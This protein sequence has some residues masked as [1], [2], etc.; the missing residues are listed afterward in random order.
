MNA[1]PLEH[2]EQAAFT[3]WLELQGLLFTA[4]AQSTYTKSWSQK[5][6]NNATGLRKGF[7]DMVVIIPRSKSKDGEGYF[8]CVEL[9]RTTGGIVSKEQKVWHEEINSLGINNTQAYICKGA[10]EA[11]KVVS[12]YLGEVDSSVF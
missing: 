8:L 3:Q 1:T 9:K 7:P 10:G 6:R 2:E 12:H 4:T 5:R 11:I